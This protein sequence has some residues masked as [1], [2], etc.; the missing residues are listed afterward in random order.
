MQIYTILMQKYF[1]TLDLHAQHNSCKHSCEQFTKINKQ[2]N[3]IKESSV[4][5]FINEAVN[6]LNIR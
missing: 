5:C 6:K 2:I 4:P 1:L 3:K